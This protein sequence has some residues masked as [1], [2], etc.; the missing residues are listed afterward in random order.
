[1]KKVFN[2][3]ENE[4]CN[5]LS[6]IYLAGRNMHIAHFG[7]VTILSLGPE[8]WKLIPDK[9]KHAST[10][11]V[12]KANIKSWTINNFPRRLCKIFVKDLG[13]AEVCPSI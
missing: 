8:F 11:L 2:F 13:F 10:L 1:M 12:F 5:L 9:I 6:G 7:N 3:Q 4:R